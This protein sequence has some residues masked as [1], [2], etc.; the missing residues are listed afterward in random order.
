MIHNYH[1][2]SFY[3]IGLL[4][5][6]SGY[7]LKPINKKVQGDCEINFYETLIKDVNKGFSPIKDYIPKYLG[8]CNIKINGNGWVN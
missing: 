6:D 8:S 4:K 5:H 7:V 3:V 2:I 1:F